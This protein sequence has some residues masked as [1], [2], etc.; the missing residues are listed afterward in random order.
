M[1]G[2]PRNLSLFRDTFNSFD[3]TGAR[4]LGSIYCMI[5]KLLMIICENI[6]DVIT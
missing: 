4:L 6:T 1:R 5:L 2:L 3:N